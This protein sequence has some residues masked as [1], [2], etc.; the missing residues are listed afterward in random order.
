MANKFPEATA[1]PW[2]QFDQ[3]ANATEIMGA[4]GPTVCTMEQCGG[5]REINEA[6]D[7]AR[8]IVTAVNSYDALRQAAE[9]ALKYIQ[10]DPVL[11]DEGIATIAQLRAALYPQ[12]K[13]TK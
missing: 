13:E 3:D 1:R 7:N 9:A 5:V 4:D 2:R 12:P 8:L 10:V 6:V 11:D